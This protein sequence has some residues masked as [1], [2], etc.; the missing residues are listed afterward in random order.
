MAFRIIG[1]LRHI[2][3]GISPVSVYTRLTKK[4]CDKPVNGLANAN[5]AAIATVRADRLFA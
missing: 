4:F 2:G 3:S 5:A 1:T